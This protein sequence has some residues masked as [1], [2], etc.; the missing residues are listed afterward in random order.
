MSYNQ[1]K[2][3][4]AISE[5]DLPA[6]VKD[7]G[8]IFLS[9]AGPDLKNPELSLIRQLSSAKRIELIFLKFFNKIGQFSSN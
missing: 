7:G 2:S 9:W 6:R 3:K 1:F 4:E 5:V 8:P